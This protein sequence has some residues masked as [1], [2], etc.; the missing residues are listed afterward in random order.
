MTSSARVVGAVS[1]YEGAWHNNGDQQLI[2]YP[3]CLVNKRAESV[4]VIP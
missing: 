1:G 4:A 3:N 2:A